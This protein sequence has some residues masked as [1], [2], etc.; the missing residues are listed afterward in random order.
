M[1]LRSERLKADGFLSSE[2][3]WFKAH[4][5]EVQGRE[6]IYPYLGDI[7]IHIRIDHEGDLAWEVEYNSRTVDHDWT[8]DFEK[9]LDEIEACLDDAEDDFFDAKLNLRR[10]K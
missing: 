1:S 4:G 7:D 10:E 2:L 6:A 9:C 3:E 8:D 5:W